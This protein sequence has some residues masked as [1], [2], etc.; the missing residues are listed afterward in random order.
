MHPEVLEPTADEGEKQ[1]CT[2]EP[3]MVPGVEE[4]AGDHGSAG[5]GSRKEGA[6][7][8]SRE[9]RGATG[10]AHHHHTPDL[11]SQQSQ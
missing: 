2:Q 1:D 11:H 3:A 8:R 4:S 10:C 9:A 5:Q 7:R 6:D